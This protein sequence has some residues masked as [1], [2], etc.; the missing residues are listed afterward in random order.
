MSH[1][2]L[3]PILLSN[4]SLCWA[5]LKNGEAALTDALACIKLK[6]D[7]PKAHYRAG[8]AWRLLGE[9]GKAADA[10]FMGLKL[11]PINKELRKAYQLS[12]I[13]YLHNFSNGFYFFIFLFDY[14]TY[15]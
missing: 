9:F 4:R 12:V 5:S 6:P 13:F 11:D 14:T 10:F 15:F 7:W 2:P 3:D 8:S 1:D